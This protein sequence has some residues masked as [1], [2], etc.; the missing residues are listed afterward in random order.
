M[1]TAG[2]PRDTE[3][4]DSQI[5]VDDIESHPT[6]DEADPIFIPYSFIS[7]AMN[8]GHPRHHKLPRCYLNL[9][10][11]VSAPLP[12]PEPSPLPTQVLPH[13]ILHVKDT[14]CTALN[15]FHLMCEYPHQP[16][17]DPDCQLS[18]NELFN[19]LPLSSTANGSPISSNSPDPPWPFANMSIYR[20]IHWFNL[21]SHKKSARETKRLVQE[22]ICAE[23]F[24]TQDLA[25][26]TIHSQNKILD[27]SEKQTPY[28]GDDWM[29]PAVE[30]HLPTGVKG[31]ESEGESFAVPG[32]H[33]QSLL[34]V[35]KSAIIDPCMAS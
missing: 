28:G 27:A 21:G 29:E 18:S 1:K 25:G 12:I 17:Y 23:D 13:I 19:V 8:N 24:N 9:Y 15:S 32:L 11:E 35:L 7:T 20:L 4:P 33:H 2:T 31:S 3:I 16:S 6:F 22:V 5:V 14:I 10:P 26:F 30:I 34:S